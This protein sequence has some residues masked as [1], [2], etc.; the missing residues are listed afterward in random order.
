[1]KHQVSSQSQPEE[2]AAYFTDVEHLRTLF[3]NVVSSPELEK[4]LLIIHGVGGVGKSSLLRMFRFHCQDAKIPNALA[5]GDDTKSEADILSHWARDLKAH[6][7]SLPNFDSTLKRYIVIQKKAEE[8]AQKAQDTKSEIAKK[9][10]KAIGKTVVETVI[11]YIPGVG[12]IV[13]TLGG[14][15]YEALVD[16]LSSFLTKSEIDLL[17]DPIKELS[18]NFLND[19]A[20][21]AQKRRLVLILDTFEQLTAQNDWVRDFAKQLHS[22]ILLIIAG[23]EMVNWDRKWEGWLAHAQVE[24]LKIMTE[25]HMRTL[26][27]RYY[28]TMV[29][30]EPDTKQV[31]AIITF[32]R[33]L[34]MVVAT[35]VRL[36]VKYGQ[37]FNIEEHR[38]EVY[39]DVVKRIR[40]GV[41]SQMLPILEAAAAVRWFDKEILRSVTGLKDVNE[42]YDELCRFPFAKSSK[43][44]WRLHDSVREIL[45]ENLH[46]DD[47]KQHHKLH[48]RAAKFFEKKLTESN[49]EEHEQFLLERLYHRIQVDE[50]KGTQ[51]FQTIAEELLRYWF[52]SRLR[53]LLTDVNNYYL[54]HKKNS[55]WRQ[56]YNARLLHFEGER[57]L[58]EEIY[59]SISENDQAESKLQAYSLCDW[60]TLIRERRIGKRELIEKSI[61]CF[62]T[63]LK[64]SPMDSKLVVSLL[65]LGRTHRDQGHWEIALRY[66]NQAL[67]FFSSHMESYG[68]ANTYLAIYH[69]YAYLGDWH[70]MFLALRKGTEVKLDIDNSFTRAEY[71]DSLAVAWV[72]AGRYSKVI[73]NIKQSIEMKQKLGIGASIG[74]LRDLGLALAFAGRDEEATHYIDMSLVDS[75]QVANYSKR[76]IAVTLGFLGTAFLKQGK[77]EKAEEYLSR[78]VEMKLALEDTSYLLDTLIWSGVLS[79]INNDLQQAESFYNKCLEY[80]WTGRRYF[81]C[82]ALTG[83]SRIKYLVGNISVVPQLLA[84]AE[85]FAERY[86]YNDQIASIRLTQG[87][88]AWDGNVPEWG[89]GYNAALSFYKES[90]IYA[91]RYNRFMLDDVLSGSSKDTPHKSIIQYCIAHGQE[92]FDMLAN[93]ENWWKTGINEVAQLRLDTMSIVTEG[94]SLLEAESMAREQ[95]PGD[96]LVQKTVI[97]QIESALNHFKSE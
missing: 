11:S 13:S 49:A 17:L 25:D 87:H 48:E 84:E 67:D 28:A 66:L 64:L 24:E 16:W 75:N 30:G 26:V 52:L 63:S 72:W 2:L 51:L 45:D 55:L 50:D 9:A 31:D 7:V 57:L 56:Y 69:Y 32:A 59:Q 94:I 41:P 92:G 70:N 6:N 21:V 97:Q 77:L 54:R 46:I 15:G 14:I 37:D 60:G 20:K 78:S 47:R 88:I 23:R 40:E 58:A 96:L 19:I 34:P 83:L 22:N 61:W 8:Q 90:L 29:G 36:W 71:L 65:Q 95:E 89:K 86:E 1:M 39:R 18:K 68:L 73:D 38:T 85:Q 80:R 42:Q 93:L 79:E 43:K 10:G 33:G 82:C 74:D 3:A 4:R 81:E 27:Y 35:A 12:P 44:G 53:A 91:L 5:S 76:E 62:E